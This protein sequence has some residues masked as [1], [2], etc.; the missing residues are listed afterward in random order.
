MSPR[1]KQIYDELILGRSYRQISDHFYISTETVKTHCRVIYGY[2]GVNNQRQLMGKI[3]ESE[4]K[5][6]IHQN[7][8]PAQSSNQITH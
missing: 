3:I 7:K 5:K 6:G 8:S 4:L 1:Q 2:F